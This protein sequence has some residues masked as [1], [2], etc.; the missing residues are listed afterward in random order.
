MLLLNQLTI[1]GIFVTPRGFRLSLGGPIIG[2]TRIESKTG[3]P[4]VNFAIYGI[5]LYTAQALIKDEFFVS[6]SGLTPYGF[7]INVSGPLLGMTSVV[8]KLPDF[9]TDHDNFHDIVSSQ[10]NLD[11]KVVNKYRK[12]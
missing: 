12:D 6:G 2:N 10:F 7:T 3:N 5:N 9:L 1:I 11:R 8:F 4:L